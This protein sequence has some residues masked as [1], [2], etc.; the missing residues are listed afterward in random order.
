MV[1]SIPPIDVVVIVAYLL[2]VTVW[3]AWLGRGQ[4][5]GTDYFLG[6]R[7]LP[8]GAVML[9]VVATE[10]STL[11]FLSIPG[12]AYLGTL[13]F[14]QLTIGYLAGRMV[15]SALLLPAYYRG[16]LTTA[17]ALL[18][19]RFGTGV[20]RF[21]SSIFMVTRLL[22]DSVRL[23]A[24]AIPLALVTGWPYPVSIAVIGALTL[25]YT[26]FG[27][28]KAV[29]WVDALQMVL[30]LVGA[31]I[32]AVVLQD[33]VAGG[34]GEIISQ[35][36]LAG[37]TTILDFQGTLSVPYTFWA[38]LLGGGF[39]TMGSHGADQ[40]I[41]QRLLTCKDLRASQKA[42]V[43][44]AVVV[45][46]QFLVFLLVG[47]GLWVFYGGAEFE[48]SDEIFARFIVGQMP[49]G[50]TGLLI[51]GIFAAAM[52]S[53][54]SSIN[55]LASAAAYDFWAPLRGLV[56]DEVKILRAGKG[57]TLLWAALLVGGATVFIP[58]ST[59][60]SAVEVALG[61]ASV[62]YGGLLGAFGLGVLSK[63]AEQ[64]GTIVG[65]VTGIGVVMTIWLTI[66]ER[67][68]W[69]WFVL[70]GTLVTFGVGWLMGRRTPA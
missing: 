30:Y 52:S 2:G 34:W 20:R 69:P 4:K 57:F 66:P 25:V 60:T 31:L 42:L 17:Y 6:N 48:R 38:G 43:W 27:G 12:V 37:K 47:L 33:L 51:A 46:A 14:L 53:L 59:R 45:M 5:G 24:T 67:V 26:Y 64:T 13:A 23:F 58:L 32:A 63:R 68:A 28:I 10:T 3:G 21:T 8:W 15:V 49:P 19:T 62:V 65:M 39:L 7:E 41:V 44:S 56:G 16:E 70:I 29:V 61:I 40:L 9:S 35:S 22:A 36:K 54:S 50:I 55:S 1:P 18:E 11:T